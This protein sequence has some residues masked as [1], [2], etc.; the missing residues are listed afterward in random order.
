MHIG[1]FTTY[2]Y[3][4]ASRLLTLKHLNSLNIELEVLNYMYD[5]NGNR[6]AMDRLNVTPKLPTP[7]V[8]ATYNSA[9]QMLTFQPEG[10]Y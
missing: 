2:T 5:K 7:V 9:N 4:K 1:S 8:N 10:G 3:Y 6:V